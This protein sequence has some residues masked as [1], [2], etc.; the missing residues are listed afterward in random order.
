M[1]L[2]VN[3]SLFN[4]VNIANAEEMI[5]FFFDVDQSHFIPNFSNIQ[6][7]RLMHLQVV[8]LQ[9]VDAFQQKSGTKSQVIVSEKHNRVFGVIPPDTPPE[10]LSAMVKRLTELALD[11][12]LDVDSVDKLIASAKRKQII[13]VPPKQNQTRQ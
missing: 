5:E 9:G 13:I 12:A 6:G 1:P 10:R 4:S 8:L 3:K 2:E 11:E 7:N